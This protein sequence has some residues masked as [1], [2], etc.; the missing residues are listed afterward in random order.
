MDVIGTSTCRMFSS[1][2]E[3]ARKST[4]ESPFFLLYGRD[5]AL[6][7]EEA[8]TQAKTRYQVD[9]MDYRTDLMDSLTSAWEL[10]REQIRKSQHKQKK[11]YDRHAAETHFRVGD[12]V[13]LHVPSATTGK[14]HK[15]SRLFHG[16][17]CISSLR[18]TTPV[19][20]RYTSRTKSP[21]LLLWAVF[22]GAHP[23]F[24]KTTF[25]LNAPNDTPRRYLPQKT[26]KTPGWTAMLLDPRPGP[27]A[28]VQGPSP[29]RDARS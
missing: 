1:H 4:K 6:P 24:H 25:G 20:S 17:Y 18:Q 19:S 21:S 16:P 12:R 23:K 14:A 15:F 13:F 11:H 22:G 2:S 29:S 28:F 26:L 3:L 5:P 9:L 8:L 27:I 10:A 7:T